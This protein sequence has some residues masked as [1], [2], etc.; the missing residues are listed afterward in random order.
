MFILYCYRCRKLLVKRWKPPVAPPQWMFQWRINQHRHKRPHPAG[1]VRWCG[2]V[3]NYPSEKL[4]C[5]RLWKLPPF[6]EA[7]N[8]QPNCP[9]LFSLPRGNRFVTALRVWMDPLTTSLFLW[10]VIFG[11]M[12]KE[13]NA[14]PKNGCAGLGSPVLYFT[15]PLIDVSLGF[16]LNLS[17]V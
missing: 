13:R 4:N 10:W 2:I 1:S 7:A 5:E 16:Q 9:R 6:W 12:A 11:H 15:L 3:L 17:Q 14:A 8:L